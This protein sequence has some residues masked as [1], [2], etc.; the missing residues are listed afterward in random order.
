[1]RWWQAWN[2]LIS[3]RKRWVIFSPS[4]PKSVVK[5][6]QYLRKGDD[7]EAMGYFRDVVPKIRADNYR[8]PNMLMFEFTQCV[9]PLLVAV[10]LTRDDDGRRRR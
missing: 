5:G 3:G 8:R 4:T 6:K 1:M 10:L 7:D 2:A 9:C